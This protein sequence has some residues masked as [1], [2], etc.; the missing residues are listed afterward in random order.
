MDSKKPEDS[1]NS[2]S[3][4]LLG[5]FRHGLS[6]CRLIKHVCLR[7]SC[8][9][10]LLMHWLFACHFF[11]NKESPLLKTMLLSIQCGCRIKE[12][13]SIT[14]KTPAFSFF[15]FPHG[16]VTIFL[17]QRLHGELYY[18]WG[19]ALGWCLWCGCRFYCK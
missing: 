14:A 16:P 9:A 1:R 15:S 13:A 18:C 8:R 4:A 12:H 11:K 3:S 17:L 5:V 2:T 10:E 6:S 19:Q 7:Q